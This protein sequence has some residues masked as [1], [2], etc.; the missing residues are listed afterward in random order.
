MI[1]I[2]GDIGG[3]KSWLALLENSVSSDS[4]II[5]EARYQSCDFAN[6]G[7][8]LHQFI[9]DASTT[10][11]A[12]EQMV[13]A[14]P[15][16]ISGGVARLTN[17]D[18]RV[19]SSE[20][21]SQFSLK[22]VKIINDFQA[23]ALGTLV[24][25]H[26]DCLTMNAAPAGGN[27]IRLVMGAGTGLGVAYLYRDLDGRYIPIATEGG[28][29]DFAPASEREIALLRYLQKRY[30]RV[31]YERILSGSGLVEL[32]CF[33]AGTTP[34]EQQIS[35]EWVNREASD[36]GDPVAVDALKLFATI[37]GRF[38]GNMA[39]AYKPDDGLYLTGGVTAKVSRWLDSKEFMNSYLDKGRMVEVVRNIPLYLVRNERVGLQGAI[40]SL[41]FDKLR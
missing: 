12:V 2:A 5:Y 17:L 32:Y 36:A 22:D 18:W 34:E 21:C 9:K 39:L 28:H 20:L 14:I 4:Q 1:A 6:I 8:L 10:V 11:A 38:A 27:H 19:S 26:D 35:A 41:N 13:L 23:V 16:P 15:G 24:L 7:A 33:C 25:Q 3:T 40:A 31:S 29:V 37:F 30:S